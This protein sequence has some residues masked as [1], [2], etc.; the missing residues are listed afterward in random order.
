[1]GSSS[2]TAKMFVDAVGLDNLAAEVNV[3]PPAVYNAISRGVFPAAWHEAGRI[4]AKGKIDCPPALFKQKFGRNH[5]SQNVNAPKDIQ[6]RTAKNVV[7]SGG[8][9][10]S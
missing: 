1:M 7:N 6:G 8:S 4:L 10:A 5:N 9:Y 3:E 2:I